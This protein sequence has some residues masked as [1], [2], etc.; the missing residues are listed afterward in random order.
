MKKLEKNFIHENR[1]YLS[2]SNNVVS[3]INYLNR[4]VKGK[5]FV[6][7]GYYIWGKDKLIKYLANKLRLFYKEMNQT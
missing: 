2:N 7:V 3:S 1:F 4:L 6:Y 5:F